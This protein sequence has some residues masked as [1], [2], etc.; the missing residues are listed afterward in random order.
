M[1][2]NS[3]VHLAKIDC[4]VKTLHKA[5]TLTVPEA[6]LVAKFPKKGIII[7]NMDE[8][9]LFIDRSNRNLI[10]MDETGL[11]LDRSNRNRG[12][13]RVFIAGREGG[14]DDDDEDTSR[15]RKESRYEHSEHVHGREGTINL[16]KEGRTVKGHLVIS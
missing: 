3:A 1:S 4:C 2:R 12:G 15:R 7:I 5:P 16:A 10:N 13:R 11:F 8:T 14:D 9:G 6:M